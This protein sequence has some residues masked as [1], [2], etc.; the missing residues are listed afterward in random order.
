MLE[1]L[2]RPLALL[3]LGLLLLAGAWCFV[4]PAQAPDVAE[5]GGYTDFQLY[6]DITAKVAAGTPYHQAAA[7]V[8]R[9]HGYPLRPF[10]TMRPPALFVLAARLGWGTMQ[11]IAMG[12]AVAAL[13]LWTRALTP[14]VGQAER[15]AALLGLVLGGLALTNQGLLAD[16][17]VWV[18]L[19]LTIALACHLR[20]WEWGELAAVGAAL[21]LRELALPYAL[22]ALAFALVQRQRR[23]ALRWL[24]L[25]ALFGLAMAVHAHFAAQVVRSDDLA[26]P[27]WS[28][29]QGLRG[30]LMGVVYT[31]VFQTLPQ[32]LAL[33]LALL[34]ALGWM[35]L[36]GRTGLFAQLLLGGY[37]LMLMLFARSDNFY[38]GFTVMPLWFIGYA[39]I[40]RACGQV[41][42]A[43]L[44][45]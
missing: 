30:F 1:R 34:P 35:A 26:S 10:V 29:G 17:E 37:A 20:G 14:L 38:W 13:Y 39:L 9:A 15:I 24:A 6:A 12:L 28:G 22:L 31:S 7:E 4:S 43:I 21:L 11:G 27:G 8:Q 36:A 41:R 45:G 16:G 2:P 33:L 40:P 42:R 18:G 25:I 44:Q 5:A 3:V 32:P 19:L 23:S